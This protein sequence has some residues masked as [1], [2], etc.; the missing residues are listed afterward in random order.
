M[1]LSQRSE[2][3]KYLQII[4]NQL[5]K[6]I[7]LAFDHVSTPLK[8]ELNFNK[9]LIINNLT[10]Y[11]SLQTFSGRSGDLHL[12]CGETFSGGQRTVFCRNYE[13]FF[14]NFSPHVQPSLLQHINNQLFT[15]ITPALGYLK[16]H[17]KPA[18]FL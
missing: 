12:R 1:S 9:S 6:K 16:N 8:S 17:P 13:D 4:D 3:V 2:R 5:F 7:Q 11:S 18:P 15:K 10:K 14:G